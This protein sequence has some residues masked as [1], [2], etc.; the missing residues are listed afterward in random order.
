[1]AKTTK[2]TKK[3]N[4]TDD[5]L[6][7]NIVDNTVKDDSPIIEEDATVI[8][9]FSSEVC[10]NTYSPNINNLDI[11][12]LIYYYEACKIICI[13]YEKEI[14]LNELEKRNYGQDIIKFNREQYQKFNSIHRR[15]RE[16]I[17]NKVEKLTE[18]E[19]W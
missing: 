12:E 1:M 2:K 10:E 11:T 8:S 4:V 14:N 15:L 19:G 18:Y 13:Q 7:E 9:L 6:N 16:I 5:Q 3:D 17:E